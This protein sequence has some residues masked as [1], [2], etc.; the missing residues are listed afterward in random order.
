M[1]TNIVCFKEEPLDALYMQNN[2]FH[3]EEQSEDFELVNLVM[4]VEGRVE[5]IMML[6]QKYHLQKQSSDELRRTTKCFI[7]K[8]IF[9]WIMNFPH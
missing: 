1:I 4:I 5:E 6:F 8:S 9:H 7:C 3:R 2:R